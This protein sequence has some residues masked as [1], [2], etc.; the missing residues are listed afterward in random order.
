MRKAAM[1][2]KALNKEN[3]HN[4]KPAYK[5]EIKLGDIMIFEAGKDPIGRCI[6]WL[7]KSTVSHA[8]MVYSDD[9]IVEMRAKGIV[10]NKFRLDEKGKKAYLLRLKTSPNATP[11]ITAANVYLDAGIKY[12]YPA[13]VILAGLLIYRHIRPTQHWR[14]VTDIILLHACYQ[15]DKIINQ[16][17]DKKNAMVCSQLVYQCYLDC[18]KN[19]II[20][21]S[22]KLLAGAKDHGETIC[23]AD[24]VRNAAD[25]SVSYTVSQDHDVDVNA[26]VDVDALADELLQA[27]EESETASQDRRMQT[28]V[29]LNNLQEKAAEFLYKLEGILKNLYPDIPLAA[30]FVTPADLLKHSKNLKYC[31][32]VH[33]S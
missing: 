20:H 25:A 16:A 23:L 28:T 11:L 14:N 29:N 17:G 26:N 27:L 24:L 13:L 6:A 19:Y 33:I 22:N 5:K 18:G 7:T 31:G 1:I 30:L 10:T 15:L 21:M 32:S 2:S 4:L 3:G 8:A 12:D 9:E